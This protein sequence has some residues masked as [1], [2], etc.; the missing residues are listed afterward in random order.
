MTKKSH[1][2]IKNKKLSKCCKQKIIRFVNYNKH[3]DIK[4]W[5][6]NNFFYIHHLKN[7]KV[8]Y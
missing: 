8:H 7:L 5:L 4:N 1:Y 2:N 6:R 3:K